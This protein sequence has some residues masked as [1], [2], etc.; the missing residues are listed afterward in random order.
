VKAGERHDRDQASR[1][2]HA[3]SHIRKLRGRPVRVRVHRAQLLR[4]H[5]LHPNPRTVHGKRSCG[6]TRSRSRSSAGTSVSIVR[7]ELGTIS[8]MRCRD[9]TVLPLSQ[10]AKRSCLGRHTEAAAVDDYERSGTSPSPRCSLASGSALVV[11]SLG[12]ADG[13]CLGTSAVSRTPSSQALRRT[14]SS[15]AQLRANGCFPMSPFL[16]GR[17]IRLWARGPSAAPAD[18]RAEVPCT[19]ADR[20]D[21]SPVSVRKLP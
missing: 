20:I 6:R 9:A 11:A 2:D 4:R 21:A 13:R 10:S 14:T 3:R 15:P 7:L 16:P 19:A 12:R 8:P 1:S 5:L 18:L 17:V